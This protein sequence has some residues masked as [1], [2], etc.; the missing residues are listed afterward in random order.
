MHDFAAHIPAYEITNNS[1]QPTTNRASI[2]I[3]CMNRVWKCSKE[4]ELLSSREKVASIKLDMILRELADCQ[5]VLDVN[6]SLIH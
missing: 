3:E 1:T 6:E 2:M 4:Y 5:I